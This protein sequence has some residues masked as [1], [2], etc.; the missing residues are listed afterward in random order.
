[1]EMPIWLPPPP[2]LPRGEPPGSKTNTPPPGPP[3]DPLNIPCGTPMDPLWTPF[4]PPSRAPQHALRTLFRP[5]GILHCALETPFG[6]QEREIC[7]EGQGGCDAEQVG[8]VKSVER[9]LKPKKGWK[10]NRGARPLQNEP[11]AHTTVSWSSWK[12]RNSRYRV[13]HKWL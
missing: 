4:G 2:S 12:R 6:P 3:Q 1:M 13:H 7:A 5:P 11:F 9:G 10:K 8:E